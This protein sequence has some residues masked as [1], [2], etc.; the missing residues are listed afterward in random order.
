MTETTTHCF[1]FGSGHMTSYPLPRGGTISDYWV[2]VELPVDFPMNHR[3]F[4]MKYFTDRF[5][6]RPEQF[7]FEYSL[8]QLKPEYFPGGCIARLNYNGFEDTQGKES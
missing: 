6:P 8:G 5:C 3:E 4:F 1:T 2:E 7:S